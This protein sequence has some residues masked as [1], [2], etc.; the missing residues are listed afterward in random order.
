MEKYDGDLYNYIDTQQP[1]NHELLKQLEVIG[2]P[3]LQERIAQQMRPSGGST[4]LQGAGVFEL[5]SLTNI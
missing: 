1:S 3:Q 2:E 5:P 4:S